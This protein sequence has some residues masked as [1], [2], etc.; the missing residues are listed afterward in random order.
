MSDWLSRWFPWFFALPDQQQNFLLVAGP[1]AVGLAAWFSGPLRW[2]F[3]LVAWRGSAV[4]VTINPYAVRYSAGN[5]HFVIFTDVTIANRH[6]EPESVG[7]ELLIEESLGDY[8]HTQPLMPEHSAVPGW[9]QSAWFKRNQPVAFP[10]NLE[11]RRAFHGYLAFCVWSQSGEIPESRSRTKL[12]FKNLATGKAIH[13]SE[14]AEEMFLGGFRPA[15]PPIDPH[16]APRLALPASPRSG[17]TLAMLHDIVQAAQGATTAPV[18][19]LPGGVLALRWHQVNKALHVDVVNANAHTIRDFKLLLIDL[20]R[21]SSGGIFVEVPEFHSHGPFAPRELTGGTT[22]VFPDSPVMFPFLHGADPAM[23]TFQAMLDQQ[24]QS[25]S[26]Q[27]PGI[28]QA[29]FSSRVG[30]GFDPALM[31]FQWRKDGPGPE[32][33]SL[34]PPVSQAAPPL[35]PVRG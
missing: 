6:N 27:E 4:K 14:Q 9:E 8:H 7:V 24:L 18:A 34:V 13:A 33:W 32:P 25:F 23:V 16:V 22:T 19:P 3:R 29:K 20:K 12:R 21:L 30:V 5:Q 31:Y 2:L 28:W 26:I 10:L 1:I 15:L 17:S 35:R 11:G